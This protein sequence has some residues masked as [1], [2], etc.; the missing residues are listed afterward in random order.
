MHTLSRSE[1]DWSHELINTANDRP[2]PIKDGVAVSM[3]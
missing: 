1:V 3:I 2:Q